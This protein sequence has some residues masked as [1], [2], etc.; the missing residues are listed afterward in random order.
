MLTLIDDDAGRAIGQARARF[1]LSRLGVR[2]Q[3]RHPA[4]GRQR[5]TGKP[6]SSA[7]VTTALLLLLSTLHGRLRRSDI[8]AIV[9]RRRDRH[10]T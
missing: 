2:S 10:S 4:C 5:L 9:W 7:L 1:V 6:R 8:S 3:H